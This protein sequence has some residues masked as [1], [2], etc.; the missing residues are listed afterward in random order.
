MICKTCGRKIPDTMMD[1]PDCLRDRSRAAMVALQAH[2]LRRV[3]AGDGQLI[4]RQLNSTRHIQMFGCEYTYCDQH[5]PENAR[6][7]RVPYATDELQKLCS[8]CRYH[9]RQMMEAACPS[10][11]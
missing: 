5:I 2:P 10:S 11:A 3:A 7:T 4:V 6:R 8:A 1:C 9:L